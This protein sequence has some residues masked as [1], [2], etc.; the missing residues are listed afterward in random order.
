MARHLQVL[1]LMVLMT[2]AC[3][4]SREGPGRLPGTAG[5]SSNGD[6]DAAAPSSDI[7]APSRCEAPVARSEA[8]VAPYVAFADEAQ[9]TLDR[10][11]LMNG[12][13]VRPKG[14][15]LPLGTLCT[16]LAPRPPDGRTV[17]V[18]C[19]GD[20]DAEL[21]DPMNRSV[22]LVDL[23]TM[24]QRTLPFPDVFHGLAWTPDGGR[25][26]VSLGRESALQVLDATADYAPLARVPL[27]GSIIYGV[28]V[29]P[30]GARAL[31]AESHS[32]T[33]AEVDLTTYRVVRRYE[34]LTFPFG[35][36]VTPDGRK[37]YV[38]CVGD[39][40]VTVLDLQEGRSLKAIPTGKNPQGMA[41]DADG[42]LFVA[43]SDSDGITRIDTR[44]DTV[45]G[46][47]SLR[48]PD[49]LG[50]IDPVTV[51][52]SGDGRRLYVPCSGEG[53]VRVLSRPD[54]APMGRVQGLDFVQDAL[55]ADGALLVLSGKGLNTLLQPP[56]EGYDASLQR[57]TPDVTVMNHRASLQVLRPVPSDADVASWDAEVGKGLDARGRAFDVPCEAWRGVLP[58]SFGTPSSRV[59]HVVYVVKENKTYD[60][61][62]GDLQGPEGDDWHAPDLAL[63]GESVPAAVVPRQYAGRRLNVTPNLHALAREFCNLVNFY[64]D[65]DR[66]T[67]GHQ[68]ATAGRLPDFFEKVVWQ[69]QDGAQFSIPG[70]DSISQPEGGHLVDHLVA[71]GKSVRIYGEFASFV[72]HIADYEE[73]GWVSYALDFPPGMTDLRETVKVQAFVKDVAAGLLRDFTYIQLMNDHTYGFRNGRPHPAYMV[74]DNDRATGMLVEALANSP[75]WD[76]TVVFILE[77]DPQDTP[78]HIDPHRSLMLVAGGPVRRG[79]TSTVLHHYP[80][81]HA[82]ALRLLGVPPLNRLDALA[83]PFFECF[84]EETSSAGYTARPMD[85]ALRN[86]WEWINGEFEVLP[87]IAPVM[88]SLVEASRALDLEDIDRAPGLAPLLWEGMQ[89]P[90]RPLP[91]RSTAAASRRLPLPADAWRPLPP[92]GIR[93]AGEV[94]P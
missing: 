31:V 62:L 42:T 52:I 20:R 13:L 16:A 22:R 74:A 33:V 38:S 30:D 81:M 45:I 53:S 27:I 72:E 49:G 36:V 19:G 48:D 46:T 57:E 78:D 50:G 67:Q 91:G 32:A 61:L 17:A 12:R 88:A 58:A 28:A 43:N 26:L 60:S 15:Y 75:F 7:A 5:L 71:H 47:T 68:W 63:F 79:H 8:Q 35:I 4:P 65:A 77:D 93:S 44:T 1:F 87:A 73:G 80:S 55:E 83:A 56:P 84:E 6:P 37:A 40:G 2:I 85:E 41:L 54:L 92:G 29:T 25:L 69:V 10:A 94:R 9:T 21:P 14:R 70:V 82:T 39:V 76:S 24:S 90:A 23:Q 59:K 89:G 18:A 64:N 34:T 66:S 3:S 86:K 51:R 11:L